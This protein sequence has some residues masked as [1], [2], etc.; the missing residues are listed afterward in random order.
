MNKESITSRLRNKAKEL[1]LNYNAILSQFFFDEFLKLLSFSRH[2]DHFTLKGGILLTYALGIQNR[3]T[4]DIDFLVKDIKLNDKDIKIVLE[5]IVKDEEKTGV[6]F[7]IIGEGQ[8]IRAEDKY[9]G[10]RFRLVGH[11]YNIRVPFAVDIA[12]G[13]PIYPT[14]I[15]DKYTTILG[16][17]I[18][19]NL[20]PLE[21]VIAEKFQTILSRAEN[22]SRSKDFY[23]IYFILKNK[24]EQLDNEALKIAVSLTFKYRNTHITKEDAYIILQHISD[25]VAIKDR[26][27][28]YQK[29]NPY[30][31]GVKFDL[32]VNSIKYLIEKVL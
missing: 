5:N 31:K 4:H 18:E 23:D 26:W 22:N 8:K 7:E 9:G 1:N 27:V 11:L 17:N 3:A 25:N 21:T 6:W 14:P 32:V 13:D 29:K 28:R 30:A 16:D 19:L 10:L 20:Y 12:T 24:S 2:K 15:R